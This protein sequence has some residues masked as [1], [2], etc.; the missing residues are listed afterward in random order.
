MPTHYLTKDWVIYHLCDVSSDFCKLKCNSVCM[1][2]CSQT[3]FKQF[4]PSHYKLRFQHIFWARRR[5]IPQD[6]RAFSSRPQLGLQTELFQH[7][8]LSI[9][10]PLRSKNP[11]KMLYLRLRQEISFFHRWNLQ[12]VVVMAT[13]LHRKTS[14]TSEKIENILIFHQKICTKY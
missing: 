7:V 4:I 10:S 5:D 12:S 9:P 3:K 2:L 14:W 13:C 11:P 6:L 8:F 1:I